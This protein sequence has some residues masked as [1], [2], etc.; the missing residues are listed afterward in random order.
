MGVQE[1]GEEQM[2]GRQRERGRN[3]KSPKNKSMV[4]W[5]VGGAREEPGAGGARWQS[6]GQP[7][8]WP[9]VELT[10]GGAMVGKGPTTPGGRLTETELGEPG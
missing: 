6:R 9:T 4:E 1:A 2:R 7:G 10:A 3:K 8:W 5:R